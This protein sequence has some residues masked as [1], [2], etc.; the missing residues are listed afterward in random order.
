MRAAFT[1]DD[2]RTSPA[3]ITR[4]VVARV[5]QATRASGMAARCAST[6]ESEMRSQILSG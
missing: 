3:M 5:S 4:F 2:P 1:V 6:T